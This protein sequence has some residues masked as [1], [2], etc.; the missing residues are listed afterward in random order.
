MK[1]T[2]SRFKRNIGSKIKNK[3]TNIKNSAKRFKEIFSEAKKK[4][5]S[6]RRSLLLGFTS[7]V[8]IFGITFF[9]SV[10]TAVAKDIPKN[11]PNPGVPSPTPSPGSPSLVPSEQIVAGLSGA[12]ATVCA[13]AIT[14]GSFLI[15]AVCGV[16]VVVGILKTQ[17]K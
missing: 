15:G 11:V 7:V 2:L 6:K 13:L 4:P 3:I 9:S 14:S 5:R 12:A 16:I 17:G 8:G 10:L 1:N